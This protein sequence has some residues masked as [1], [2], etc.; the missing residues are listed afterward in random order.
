MTSLPVPEAP[1][2]DDE[3]QTRVWRAIKKRAAGSYTFD[4][5]AAA[6]I[7]A[8]RIREVTAER[9]RA[10][11]ALARIAEEAALTKTAMVVRLRAISDIAEA[12]LGGGQNG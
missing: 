12:A 8:S 4:H 6:A 2:L 3:I 11:A 7:E 5:L 10:V 9:D 1:D